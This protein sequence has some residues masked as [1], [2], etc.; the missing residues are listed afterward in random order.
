[1]TLSL[2]L[3]SPLISEADGI[4][5][6]AAATTSHTDVEMIVFLAIMLHKAPASFGLVT[7]LMHEGLE[8]HRIKKHLLFFA[9]AAP[10]GALVTYLGLSESA[11]AALSSYNATGKW[12]FENINSPR[13]D[14]Y[15]LIAFYPSAHRYRHALQ[16][17]DIFVRRDGAHL[18]GDYTASRAQ[19]FRTSYL[20]YR[21][22][23]TIAFN[24]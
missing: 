7:F 24:A 1:M 5:L 21:S 3:V 10:V 11:Q 4:A 9:L 12:Q 23:S 8:R 17:W 6:G 2:I 16:C 22:V 15:P 18:A 13:V 20:G 19:N 14:D